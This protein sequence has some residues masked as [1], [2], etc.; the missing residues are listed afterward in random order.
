MIA[1][2]APALLLLQALL[3]LL[4]LAVQAR[5]PSTDIDL[6]EISIDLLDNGIS[7]LP[8]PNP[9][10]INSRADVDGDAINSIKL[11]AQQEM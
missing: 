4:A 1:I 5:I 3:A 10:A 7:R 6:A 11:S 8:F 9:S 2:S